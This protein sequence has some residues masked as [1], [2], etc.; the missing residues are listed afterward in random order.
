MSS[1]LNDFYTENKRLVSEYIET[2]LQLLKLTSVRSLA[3]TLSMLI[4]VTLFTF[5]VLFFL[6]F[7]VI[8]FSWWMSDKLGSAALGFLSGGGL[9]LLILLL[10]IVFR[11]PLFLNPLIR[12]FI[13]SST[14]EEDENDY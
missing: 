3:R 10:A 6:L 13:Q 4:L 14:A 5:M 11:K 2:R 1:N 12:L 7:V 8:A 9:F